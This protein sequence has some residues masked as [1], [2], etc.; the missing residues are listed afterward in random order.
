M[1]ADGIEEEV[2]ARLRGDSSE[3]I[4]RGPGAKPGVTP[5]IEADQGGGI[6]GIID[7]APEMAKV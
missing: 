5:A 4:L 2:K 6:G 7:A 3:A 1:Q